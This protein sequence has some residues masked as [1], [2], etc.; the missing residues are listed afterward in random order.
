[1]KSEYED[2][3]GVVDST[4]LIIKNILKDKDANSLE[5]R[6]ELFIKIGHILPN[7]GSNWDPTIQNELIIIDWYDDF[8]IQRYQT[9]NFREF[10]TMLKELDP[11]YKFH[12]DKL[13]K[14]KVLLDNMDALKE[15]I[16]A[17]GYGGFIYDW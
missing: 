7:L 12:T 16:L 14:Y 4:I 15:Q 1:M 10:I 11:K 3:I 5:E 9:V 6:W 2:L 8:Y 17:S 13:K